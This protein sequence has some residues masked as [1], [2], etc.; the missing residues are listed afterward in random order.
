VEN[1]P[2]HKTRINL[3]NGPELKGDRPQERIGQG[4]KGSNF[5]EECVLGVAQG[6]RTGEFESETAESKKQKRSPPK[7]NCRIG[8][9][10]ATKHKREI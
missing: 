5:G 8:P 10:V 7:S 6:F 9:K 2:A 3:D 4:E 1:V